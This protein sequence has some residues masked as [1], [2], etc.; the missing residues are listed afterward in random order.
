MTV[1]NLLSRDATDSILTAT[2]LPNILLLAPKRLPCKAY[3]TWQQRT[4]RQADGF[5][6][7]ATVLFSTL[8]LFYYTT[9]V[10]S[11]SKSVTQ[12]SKRPS[13]ATPPS[14]L[15]TT[16]PPIHEITTT[17]AHA[18]RETTEKHHDV[19]NNT[20]YKR[21]KKTIAFTELY[22]SISIKTVHTDV[23]PAHQPLSIFNSNR[24]A[25]NIH[26]MLQQPTNPL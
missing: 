6:P 16:N 22:W 2:E 7:W 20:P 15:S 17:K 26:S 3:L 4:R 13:R 5:T 24:Q 11:Y 19:H 25:T 9:K 18:H 1:T 21:P 10:T 12:I 23:R 14:S 8:L